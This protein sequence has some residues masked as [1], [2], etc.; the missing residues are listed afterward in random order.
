ME[1]RFYGLLMVPEE[2][3]RTANLPPD[4]ASLDIYL[5]CAALSA[6]SFAHWE[7]DWT[8]VTDNAE[9]VSRRCERLGLH[10]FAVRQEE[11]TLD[12]PRGIPFRLAHFKLE[13]LRRFASGDYGAC[14][15]L[16]DLDTVCLAPISG[17][18]PLCRSLHAYRLDT[19]RGG[20]EQD[21]RLPES[22]ELLGCSEAEPRW[23]GGEFLAGPAAAFARLWRSVDEIWPLY[24]DH[25]RALVHA[26][27]EMVLAAAL[28][29]YAAEGGEIIDAGRARLVERYWTASTRHRPHSFRSLDD[30]GI[31]HLPADKDFLAA[32]LDR[33]FHPVGFRR[34]LDRHVR[35]KVLARRVAGLLPGRGY[36][37]R[38]R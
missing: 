28:A 33:P 23:W 4:E 32:A 34:D 37:P 38:Y 7:H 5:R 27:D 1:P 17:A 29:R 11:F 20:E 6:R 13:L 35:R 15:G 8:L 25:W 26:G 31:L 36:A 2:G 14:V 3:E 21:P 19:A 18:G 12:V 9:L 10:G 30:V 24:R 22:L 16:V